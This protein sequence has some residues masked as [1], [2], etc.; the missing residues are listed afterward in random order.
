MNWR[1]KDYILILD[2]LYSLGIYANVRIIP[3]V[4]K[5]EFDNLEQVMQHEIFRATPPFDKG[6]VRD[7]LMKYFKVENNKLVYTHSFYGALIYW[8]KE[9]EYE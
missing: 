4:R 3:L 9:E 6:K 7:I 1:K 2:V 5:Y 8:Y